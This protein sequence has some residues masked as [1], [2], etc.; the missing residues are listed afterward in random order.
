MYFDDDENDSGSSS[1]DDSGQV[2]TVNDSGSDPVDL[3]DKQGIVDP[4]DLKQDD[5]PEQSLHIEEPPSPAVPP[6][7]SEFQVIVSGRTPVTADSSQDSNSDGDS[8]GGDG[9]DS[10]GG[11]DQN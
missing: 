8:G 3:S 4:A 6:D 11:G 5:P 2:S 9:S 1:N 10:S 7:N